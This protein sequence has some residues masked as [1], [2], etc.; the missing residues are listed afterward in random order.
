MRIGVGAFGDEGL[1]GREGGGFRG[2]RGGVRGESVGGGVQCRGGACLW[3][4]IRGAEE[5][6]AGP[7]QPRLLQGVPKGRRGMRPRT[8][9][10]PGKVVCS[11]VLAEF[12][13]VFCDVICWG[14]ELGF[15]SDSLCEKSGKKRKWP[16]FQI[17]KKRKKRKE[18][19]QICRKKS[20]EKIRQK[21]QAKAEKQEKTKMFFYEL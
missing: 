15:P 10:V 3:R 18:A 17:A 6:A 14:K 20:L 11:P 12:F 5:G 16:N 8:A 1:G 4:R 2:R 19:N 21:W 9:P 7:H 13:A